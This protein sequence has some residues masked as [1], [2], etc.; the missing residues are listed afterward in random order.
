MRFRDVR[1]VLRFLI[2]VIIC[3]AIL[4]GII[5]VFKYFIP[6]IGVTNA[7]L[8]AFAGTI[9]AA[10]IKSYFDRLAQIESERRREKQKNYDELISAIGKFVRDPAGSNDDF[11]TIH[12]KSW[13]YGNNEV[14]YYTKK[15]IDINRSDDLKEF[16][17]ALELLLHSMRDEIGLD[18][19]RH[20]IG[21]VFPTATKTNRG[22]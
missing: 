15:L 13:I 17:A 22:T 7:A 14:V 21:N 19:I 8:I 6:E 12:L 11:S 20:R 1:S 3:L 5:R 2:V 9:L 4:G 16:N 10:V 18:P